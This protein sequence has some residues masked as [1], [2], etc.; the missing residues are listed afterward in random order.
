MSHQA[1]V[2]GGQENQATH[3]GWVWSGVIVF[4]GM[5]MMFLGSVHVLGGLIAVFEDD[6]YVVRPSG[7][8]VN[9][10]YSVWGVI[11]MAIGVVV[12]T[13]GWA[14]FYRRKW[15]R[16][17][18]II[19]ALVSALVNWVFLPAFPVWYALMIGLDVLVV[20]AV[21]V[22]GDEGGWDQY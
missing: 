9:I 14:L 4:A 18:A 13:A 12:A 7:L 15:A 2:T 16:V 17:V 22:H 10:D 21:T 8:I 19:V 1:P 11:H 3:S 5:M 6:H 20:W